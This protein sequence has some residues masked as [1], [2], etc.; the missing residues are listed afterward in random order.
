MRSGP[1]SFESYPHQFRPTQQARV[2]QV[3]EDDS[4]S[5]ESEGLRVDER[6]GYLVPVLDA[7]R[8]M[9]QDWQ[10]LGKACREWGVFRLVNH[11]IPPALLTQIQDQA[12]QLFSFPFEAKQAM[13]STTS[14]I[15]YFWG[16]AALAPSGAPLPLPNVDRIE[17][18]NVPVSQLSK[19]TSET[20][21]HPLLDSFMLL[22]REY[23]SHLCRLARL[24]YEAIGK[25]LKLDP[26]LSCSNLDES[27]GTIRVYRYPRH[28]S[29]SAPSLGLK[30]H[31]D[32]S[33][34]TILVQN[35]VAGLQVLKDGR[36]VSVQPINNT[37]LVVNI[38]DMLQVLSDDEYKSVKHRVV[39]SEE[40]ENKEEERLS[41]CYFVFP[42][43]E[44]VIR[45]SCYRP[46]TYAQFRAQVQH[47]IRDTGIKLG[48]HHFK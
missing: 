25:N 21:H 46:F 13:V 18:F 47:D 43:E 28:L 32:S 40:E 30:E 8:V 36:W 5:R 9:L 6:D 23:E 7:Q 33:L 11:G 24:M 17:G 15:S 20:H 4:I 26:A 27:T 16:T 14:S 39:V 1:R 34:L 10:L 12:K 41:V 44:S 35:N 45:S 22:L 42:A 48:L 19:F 29:P 2:E 31:T 3:D 38:G 37:S